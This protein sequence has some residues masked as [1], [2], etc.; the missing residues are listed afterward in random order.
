MAMTDAASIPPM[1][2]VPMMRRA[3]APAP[4]A[5]H[6]GALPRM[7]ANAVIRMG[8][9]RIR[10]PTKSGFCDAFA[11][12]VFRFGEL[13][14]QNRVLRSQPDQHDQGD[15]GIHIIFEVT[16]PEGEKAPKTAMGVPK[17][18][19]QGERPTFVLG[20]ENQEYKQQ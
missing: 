5:S 13:H 8:R 20:R 11:T 9:R 6:K 12:L 15:L 14:N 19:A 10:A 18:N 7:K 1:T 16:Q 2:A 4:D 3:T 17:Q